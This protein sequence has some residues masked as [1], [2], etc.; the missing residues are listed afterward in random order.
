MEGHRLVPF[1][2][3][4]TLNAKLFTAYLD[5]FLVPTL[6]KGDIVL[7]DNSSV[8]TAKGAIDPIIKAGASVLFIPRYSPDFNPI[9][10]LWSKL[11]SFLRKAKARTLETLEDAIKEALDNI[12]IDDIQS[13]YKHD[14]YAV[15]SP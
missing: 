5:K 7:M 6:S 14:G 10:L 12:T 15:V 13:W 4:G 8:H 1:V 11:K 9:E 2:F 3:K